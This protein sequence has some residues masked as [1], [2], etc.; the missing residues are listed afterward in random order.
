MSSVSRS[1]NGKI[2]A[3]F[4]M[5]GVARASHLDS[6][7][8][9]S[10][11][12]IRWCTGVDRTGSS[13]MS[14]ST[15]RRQQH[16][17]RESRW[18]VVLVKEAQQT[19]DIWCEDLGCITPLTYECVQTN[20]QYGINLMYEGILCFKFLH[21]WEHSTRVGLQKPHLTSKL[22]TA[23]GD[24]I[25]LLSFSHFVPLAWSLLKK[26]TMVRQLSKI[27]SRASWREPPRRTY[28]F[29]WLD[30]H[31]QDHKTKLTAQL[32]RAHPDF[33]LQSVV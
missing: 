8:E 5:R 14:V 17:I 28:G 23:S 33:I 19:C 3:R 12:T 10:T 9:H 11:K 27:S 22:G 29:Q 31:G 16:S 1:T 4:R 32:K 21:D 13:W 2:G 15:F 26:D 24:E 30:G 20:P 18:A 25:R 7:F 6:K